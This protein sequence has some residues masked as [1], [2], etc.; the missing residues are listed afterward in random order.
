M[1]ATFVVCVKMVYK[2]LM[3]FLMSAPNVCID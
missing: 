2:H 1:Q 3:I